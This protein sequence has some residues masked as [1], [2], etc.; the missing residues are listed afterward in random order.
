MKKYLL[1]L[2]V[3]IAC[4]GT[5]KQAE[6]SAGPNSNAAAGPPVIIYKTRVDY[7]QNV[8][9][10][11]SDDKQTLISYPGPEDLLVDG[12]MATPT[13]LPKGYLL[14]NRGINQ[15]V[16]FL[17]LTYREYAALKQRPTPQEIQGMIIDRDPLTELCN[18]GSRYNYADEKAIE[19][20]VKDK[21]KRC[22]RLK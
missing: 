12:R 11:L 4:N 17:K 21:L 13:R 6:S 10:I 7:E 9:V 14:D 19:G 8:P 5:K 20:L 2:P 22:K 16:A 1:L 18:C 15:N 3:L